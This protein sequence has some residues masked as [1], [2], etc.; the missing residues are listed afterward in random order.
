MAKFGELNL[1]DH[2]G[3]IYNRNANG[4]LDVR[5]T[6]PKF[7]YFCMSFLKKNAYFYIPKF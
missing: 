7:I 1:I 6:L 3:L 2:P 4:V 5:Y